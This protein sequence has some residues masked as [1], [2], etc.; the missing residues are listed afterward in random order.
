MDGQAAAIVGSDVLPCRQWTMPLDSGG[1]K[2]ISG[3]THP[4]GPPP[5]RRRVV[6][7]LVD[8]DPESSI[9]GRDLDGIQEAQEQGHEH[10]IAVDELDPCSRA[11][12]T[13]WPCRPR[14]SRSPPRSAAVRAGPALHHLGGRGDRLRGLAASRVPARCAPHC[15]S[16]RAR[17]G[18]PRRRRRTNAGSSQAG[19]A[20][21]EIRPSTWRRRAARAISPTGQPATPQCQR[22]GV[23]LRLSATD[24]SRARSSDHRGVTLRD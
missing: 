23:Q 12:A 19:C 11:D 9:L 5:D 8:A 21:P 15:A 22:L 14:T 2:A 20:S 13:A 18:R 7:R 3:H 4:L 10:R 16:D 1:L 24:R 6:S 17:R